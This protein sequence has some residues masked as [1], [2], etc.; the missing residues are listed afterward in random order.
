[1]VPPPALPTTLYPADEDIGSKADRRERKRKHTV[2]E[3][4]SLKPRSS[5]GSSNTPTKTS[6]ST[7]KSTPASSAKSSPGTSSKGDGP[8][9]KRGKAKNQTPK[10]QNPG[11][12]DLMLIKVSCKIYK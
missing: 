12:E 1:M 4:F 9:A 3:L 5:T 8:V 7:S 11:Q 10:L 6:T 2:T